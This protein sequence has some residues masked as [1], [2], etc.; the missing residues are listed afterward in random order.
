MRRL[1]FAT[2]RSAAIT[3][4]AG[5]LLVAAI[6]TPTIAF[7][8][9]PTTVHINGQVSIGDVVVEVQANAKG[10]PTALS[11]R[12]MDTPVHSGSDFV[13][14]ECTFP[15][16]G[17]ISGDIITLTGVVTQASN[18][19]DLGTLVAVIADSSTGEIEFDFGPFVLT[20]TGNV[21]VN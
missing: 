4:S 7:A 9:K 21:V 5:V 11:G 10:S 6:V 18:P 13:P 17:S 20:G 15:L 2:A 8:E 12:G 16:E 14:G 19:D 3:V 1:F